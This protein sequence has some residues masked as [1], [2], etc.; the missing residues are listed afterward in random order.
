MDWI[1]IASIVSS[2]IVAIVSLWAPIRLENQKS[3]REEARRKE[4]LRRDELAV[5]VAM[6]NSPKMAK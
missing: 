4:E 2:L 6:L 1:P 5:S 3:I